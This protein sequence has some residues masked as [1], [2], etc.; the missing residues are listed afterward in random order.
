MDV[1]G[2]Y[3]DPEQQLY[4]IRTTYF[5]KRIISVHSD[6]ISTIDVTGDDNGSDV[7]LSVEVD[8]PPRFTGRLAAG[9]GRQA[10]VHGV[11]RR[12]IRTIVA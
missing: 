10:A 5:D 7:E 2:V 3:R 11:R 9:L 12:G 1:A 6:A 4:S 8:R